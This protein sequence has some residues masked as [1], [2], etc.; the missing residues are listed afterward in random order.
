MF[1]WHKSCSYDGEQKKRFHLAARARLRKLA[2][3]L[4]LPSGT[5]IIRSNR[6]GIAV[7]GE[8]TLHHG[9]AYVQVSQFALTSGHGILIRTCKGRRDYTG[10]PNNFVALTLLDDIPAFAA[11]VRAVTGIGA[12]DAGAARR[13]AA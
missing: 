1:Q 4:R 6:G 7:S 12:A 2:T 10:G 11:C 13:R 8:I 3:E 9:R 5:Y